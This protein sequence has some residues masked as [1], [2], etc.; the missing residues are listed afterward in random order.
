MLAAER[1]QRRPYVEDLGLVRAALAEAGVPVTDPLL[2]FHREFAGHIVEVGFDEGVLG[3]IHREV[4]VQ[5]LVRPMKVGGYL[6]DWKGR[7]YVACADLHASY[8]MFLEP[9]GTF[10]S[11]GAVAS[12]YFAYTE[13]LAFAW[14][15]A[16]RHPM[17]EIPLEGQRADAA[18]RQVIAPRF[19]GE[20]VEDLSDTFSQVFFTDE[21]ILIVRE[22]GFHQA[23]VAMDRA[24]GPRGLAAELQGL[25][26][27][28]N[29]SGL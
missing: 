2:D 3:I 7:W 29:R 5:S 8:E 28:G 23:W 27:R 18:L 21:A 17:K 9:D 22:N 15:F 26:V 6:P 4:C 10:H 12:S 14:E 19:A 16:Q 20:R 13:Q 25:Q 11:S 24:I 1:A